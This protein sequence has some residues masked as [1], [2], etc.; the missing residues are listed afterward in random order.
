[1]LLSR[2]LQKASPLPFWLRS[3]CDVPRER[4]IDRQIRFGVAFFADRAIGLLLWKTLLL[5]V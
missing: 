2:A 3:T 1:M 5:N 4:T